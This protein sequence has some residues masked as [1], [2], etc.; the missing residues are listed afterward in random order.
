MFVGYTDNEWKNERIIFGLK[1]AATT[2]LKSSEKEPAGEITIIQEI[3][4]IYIY[5][6]I[7]L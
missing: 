6:A 5:I 4:Y 3:A 1:T 2:I 7:F